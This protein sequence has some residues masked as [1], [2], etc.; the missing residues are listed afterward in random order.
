MVESEAF[1]F[2]RISFSK[3]CLL[4]LSAGSVCHTERERSIIY[5]FMASADNK[6]SFNFTVFHYQCRKN[7]LLSEVSPS[8]MVLI[9][10]ITKL[11]PDPGGRIDVC[12]Q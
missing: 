4:C 10:S 9:P 11:K 1:K 8:H 2:Q 7:R 12:R 3:F 6:L 5:L